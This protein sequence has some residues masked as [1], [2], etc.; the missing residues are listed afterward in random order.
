MYVYILVLFCIYNG[1]YEREKQKNRFC[2][3]KSHLNIFHISHK[4]VDKNSNKNSE[5][6]SHIS[7]YVQRDRMFFISHNVTST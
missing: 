2:Y 5:A 3:V 1:N 4:F 7:K 6:V